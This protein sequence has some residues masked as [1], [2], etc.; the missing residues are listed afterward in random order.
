[1]AGE[2]KIRIAHGARWAICLPWSLACG[3]LAI[4][5]FNVGSRAIDEDAAPLIGS[6]FGAVIG[7]WIAVEMAVLIAPSFARYV[8]VAA[9][10]A[11]LSLA[12]AWVIGHG[13]GR[14]IR[15]A[16]WPGACFSAT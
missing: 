14:G 9:W 3:I 8:A 13:P 7:G 5:I 1:V 6:L 10:L 4:L 15:Q 2:T 11:S 16:G 12:V